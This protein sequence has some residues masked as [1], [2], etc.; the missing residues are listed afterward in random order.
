MHESPDLLITESRKKEF[1]LLERS[2]QLKWPNNQGLGF[3]GG[4]S[5]YLGIQYTLNRFKWR[6]YEMEVDGEWKF[7]HRWEAHFSSPFL[8]HVF[9]S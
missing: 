9:T 1:L 3:S 5:L 7:W 8:G 6:F 2:S 4:F